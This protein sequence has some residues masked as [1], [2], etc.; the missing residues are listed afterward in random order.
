MT[1]R[2]WT[3]RCLLEKAKVAK[4]STFQAK[5]PSIPAEFAPTTNSSHWQWWHS[6]Q[7]LLEPRKEDEGLLQLPMSTHPHVYV[8]ELFFKWFVYFLLKVVFGYVLCILSACS[9]FP[10]L[11]CFAKFVFG[12]WPSFPFSCLNKHVWAVKG[13]FISLVFQSTSIAPKA[14]PPCMTSYCKA[15]QPALVEFRVQN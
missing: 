13:M 4:L 7:H 3:S 9:C 14:S 6:W 10:I 8:R 2:H 1:Y 12:L 5:M 15:A 11:F